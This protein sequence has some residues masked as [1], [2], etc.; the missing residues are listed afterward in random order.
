[1]VHCDFHA[2]APFD[3]L[4]VLALSSRFDGPPYTLHA[5][6]ARLVFQYSLCRVV[7]MVPSMDHSPAS[8]SGPF[9]TRSVESF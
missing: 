2:L 7:L 4:S 1:M 6:V 5:P 9:S 3:F 8:P